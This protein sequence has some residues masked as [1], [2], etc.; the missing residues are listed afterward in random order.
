MKSTQI[1]KIIYMVM[2]I[3]KD[4]IKLLMHAFIATILVSICMENGWI[5]SDYTIDV[6][7]DMFWKMYSTISVIIPLIMFYKSIMGKYKV[8]IKVYSITIN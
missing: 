2:S 6:S 4:A 7:Y 8:K 3:A 5:L 1:R